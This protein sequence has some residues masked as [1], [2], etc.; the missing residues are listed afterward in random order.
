M[1]CTIIIGFVIQRN[2]FLKVLV[3]SDN[4]IFNQNLTKIFPDMYISLLHYKLYNYGT[5]RIHVYK[6][7][8]KHIYTHYHGRYI[9]LRWGNFKMAYY[10][11]FNYSRCP[12]SEC[13]VWK[14]ERN[15]VQ[16]SDVRSSDIQAVWFV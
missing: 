3:K 15:L 12:K 11:K 8:L 16:I 1:V 14:T 7:I 6:Y 2:V 10:T 9:F 5:N 13:S 4:G